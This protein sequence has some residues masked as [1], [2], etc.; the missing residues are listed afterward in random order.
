MRSGKVGTIFGADGNSVMI[1]D[2]E[3]RGCR[4]RLG[5]AGSSKRISS[6]RRVGIEAMDPR[7][8]LR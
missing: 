7:A 6:S 4:E 8:A 3:D 5:D 2:D 1:M